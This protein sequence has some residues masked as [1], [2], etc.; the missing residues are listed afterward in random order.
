MALDNVF[1]QPIAP[2]LSRLLCMRKWESLTTIRIAENKRLVGAPIA[3]DS[4]AIADDT[5]VVAE[6]S[7]GLAEDT[8]GVACDAPDNIEQEIECSSQPQE[9]FLGMRFDTLAG[10]KAHY[11]AYA[12]VMGFSIKSNT[13]RRSAYTNLVEKQQLVCNKFRMP[14]PMDDAAGKSSNP[15]GNSSKA[16][17]DE[18]SSDEEH[19]DAPNE[20]PLLFRK[21][22]KKRRRESI[23]QTGCKAK[24]T[25]KL[26]EGR[27]EV[28]FFVAEHNHELITK[29]SLTKYLLSHK[30]I[31]PE[32]EAFLR[33]LDD[34]NLETGQMMTLMSTFY[35]NGF[36]VP[37][38][39]KTISNF[40]SK[41]RSERKGD[42]MAETVSYFMVK[43]KEDPSFYFNVKL[44]EDE[45]VELL[46]WVD[47]Q[48]LDAMGGQAPLNIITDQDY[49]MRASIANVFPNTVHRNCRWHIM[50]KAQEKLGS[51]LGRRPAVSQDYNEC[52]DMSM[53]PD[54]FEQKWATFLAKFFPFLQSTQRSEGFNAVLKRYVNSRNSILN[55]VKQYEKIQVKILVKEG[56]NDYR[57]D[58]LTQ[59]TWSSYPIEKQ[60]FAT[61]TR[62][63][64][65][66]FR[67]EFK[68]TGRYNVRLQQND[69]YRL[70][71]N[72]TCCQFYGSRSYLVLA[73]VG[74]EEY[75][76]ECGKVKR[77]G[78]LCCHILKV[79]THL[80]IDEI[81]ERYIMRRWTQNAVPR[82]VARPD[83]TQ[84]DA[85]PPESL[86]QI[87][88]ANLSVKYGELARI[89]CCLD[90]ANATAEKYIRVTKAEITHLNLTRRKDAKRRR[91]T[92]ARKASTA[93]ASS[94]PATTQATTAPAPTTAPRPAATSGGAPATTTPTP[95]TIAAS[96][97]SGAATV[98]APATATSGCAPA[99]ASCCPATTTAGPATAAASTAS[100]AATASA[101]VD[102][103]RVRNQDRCLTKGR[104]RA[105]RYE[106][107]LELHPK[108]KNK[109]ALCSSDEHNSAR[110]PRKLA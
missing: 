84:P 90:A 30:N 107:A 35:A 48:Y 7:V 49:A 92:A 20:D 59:A 58:H 61:Y 47:G 25:V 95:A 62:D 33:I 43:Q 70:E 21:V 85:L 74:D 27:W 12:C 34:C 9:P 2:Q 8:T 14:K 99:T 97:V 77:D 57:T 67:D 76:C 51:F 15:T 38:T 42:D 100:G 89:G 75:S 18:S 78:L 110:C 94:S 26:I 39:T 109:C 11:N 102:P 53:T 96:T 19:V 31:S 40:R 93:S 98:P 68:L 65:V 22:V 60:A 44:D 13:S 83:E 4:T 81:P 1:N 91:E 88:M 36:I 103:N 73:Q 5:N 71:P 16:R 55:F 3:G 106:N 46:F 24:M 41:I 105:K 82:K 72:M 80:G 6:D 63:I 108:K 66:K 79:F 54:E 10:A 101:S 69:L 50:K 86:K 29:P 17:R 23:K 56:G 32:E 28:I 104:P 64:Y 52:V 87:R 45:R 37:Y